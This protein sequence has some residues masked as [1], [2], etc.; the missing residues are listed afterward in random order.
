[1]T[2]NHIYPAPIQ[3]EK[4]KLLFSKRRRDANK[5]DFGHVLVIGGDHGM[6]GAVRMAGEAALRVGAGLVSVATRAEHVCD[7]N[8]SRPEIMCHA[9]QN[10]QDLEP[11]LKKATVIVVG[12]GLGKSDWSRELFQA[13]IH[14][15]KPKI[16][17]A[18]ALNMLSESPF[19]QSDWILTPHPG[20]AGR[21]LSC[22]AS[23]IQQNRLQATNQLL[24]KYGGVI[25][26]KGA[27]TLVQTD[28]MPPQ[29]CH[30]GNPG[31]ATGGMGD[32]LSG[33]LGG[34]VAQGFSLWNAAVAGV[35]LHAKAADEAAK[36]SGER[37]LIATDLM[38]YLHRLV[39]LE[40]S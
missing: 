40:V 28:N 31:M 24:E 14:A 2:N 35:M 3:W 32:V 15:Q 8:T 29:I 36:A 39:N 5:S 20:E 26:L 18:D 22:S 34:L 1:M 4:I 33:V 25:V 9:I 27:D 21:L 16:V 23:E 19:T 12:P 10:K 38:L 6:G 37:G 30:A 11:L 17:D 13:A 7:M